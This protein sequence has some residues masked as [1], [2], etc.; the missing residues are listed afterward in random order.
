MFKH[1]KIVKIALK[2]PLISMYIA[3]S[4]FSACFG[5]YETVVA[6]LLHFIKLVA[7]IELN[8]NTVIR[9]IR[10]LIASDLLISADA[11][12]EEVQALK[13]SYEVI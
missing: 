4:L 5:G 10:A 7:K 12:L 2:G 9:I 13:Y 3:D 6:L 11:Y 1:K 8:N